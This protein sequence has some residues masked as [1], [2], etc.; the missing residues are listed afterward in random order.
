MNNKQWEV[1]F[2]KRFSGYWR[3]HSIG[4][5][6]KSLIKSLLSQR[7]AEIRKEYEEKLTNN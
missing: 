1:E 7:E 4:D 3:G 2:D 6:I 5:Q